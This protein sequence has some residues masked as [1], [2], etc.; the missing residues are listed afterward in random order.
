MSYAKSF[1]TYEIVSDKFGRYGSNDVGIST[2]GYVWEVVTNI[3]NRGSTNASWFRITP[4]VAEMFTPTTATNTQ[5]FRYLFWTNSMIL[6]IDSTSLSK[7]IWHVKIKY[8]RE[9]DP[10]VHFTGVESPCNFT[11]CNRLDWTKAIHVNLNG[12][13]SNLQI[14]TNA[15]AGLQGVNGIFTTITNNSVLTGSSMIANFWLQDSNCVFQV[16]TNIVSGTDP[17]LVDIGTNITCG[18]FEVSHSPNTQSKIKINEV[19]VERIY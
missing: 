9:L 3:A 12:Y 2:S 1:N 7:R 15:V 16:E 10:D 14:S 8:T 11:L 17:L 5:V 4:G 6:G 13:Y 19:L 18:Y